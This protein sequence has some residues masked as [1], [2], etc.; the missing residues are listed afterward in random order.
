MTLRQAREIS[1][2]E[3]TLVFGERE[4]T[5]IT[6]WLLE[7]VTGKSK[8][9]RLLVQDLPL[10]AAHLETWTAAME[11]LRKHRPIQYVTG[12]AWFRGMEMHVDDRVLIPRPETEE[13]VE[14]ILADLET[15]KEPVRILDVGTGSGCIPI[16]LKKEKPAAV[17]SACDISGGALEV[18]RK[19]AERHHTAIE[20]HQL[21]ILE[22]NDWRRLGQYDIIVSNPPYI[23]KSEESQIDVHVRAFEPSLALFV[24]ADDPLLFYRALAKLGKSNLSPSG[25]LYLEIHEERADEVSA[26]FAEAGYASIIKRKDL[27]GKDRM[28][29]L[30]P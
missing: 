20:W 6:D 24:P 1:R 12:Q 30:E 29:K 10:S 23:S 2:R 11:Q 7:F 19:N 28:M 26:C 5:A 15:E 13:L 17:V 25:R 4:G 16:A 8:T 18:A 22:E 3:L 9:A 27:Q 21:D 14:W